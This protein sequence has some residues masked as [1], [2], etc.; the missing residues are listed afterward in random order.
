MYSI[1]AWLENQ[2][3]PFRNLFQS[4]DQYRVQDPGTSLAESLHFVSTLL[5]FPLLRVPLQSLLA[6]FPKLKGANSLLILLYLFLLTV[7]T[8]P[9]CQKGVGIFQKIAE[10]WAVNWN[11]WVANYSRNTWPGPNKVNLLHA[12]S[13]RFLVRKNFCNI[14]NRWFSPD[15]TT[16]SSYRAEAG[17]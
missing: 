5:I 16:L 11:L 10:F 1:P 12:W 8:Y 3:K 6:K 15:S 9:S 2:I 13:R 7:I 4:P 14:H 17:D